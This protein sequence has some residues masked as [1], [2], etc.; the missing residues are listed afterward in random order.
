MTAIALPTHAE[1]AFWF[2]GRWIGGLSLILGPL[3]LLTAAL[4]RIRFHFFFDTQLAA[5]ADHPALITS[6]YSCFVVGCMFTWPGIVTLA[7][8]IGQ[9]HPVLATWGGM[10]AIMG[11]IGRVFHGGIDHLAFQLV[12]VQSLEAATAAVRDSYQVFHVV[13]YFNG[14]MMIGWPVLALG[15]WRAG[16]FGWPRALALAS[17]MFLPLGTLKGTRWES[18]WLLLGLCVAF[19]PFGVKVLRTGPPPSRTVI[20]WGVGFVSVEVL[21]VTLSVLFPEI[22][23]H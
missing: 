8:A 23:K 6:A 11:L 21:I 2:P 4:L 10:F 7:R 15:A 16:L 17:M 9:T 14:M 20:W 5:Y 3:L 1:D 12:N 19:I 22:M 13:R 18:P